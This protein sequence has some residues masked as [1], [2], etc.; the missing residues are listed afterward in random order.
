MKKIASLVT[1]GALLFSVTGVASAYFPHFGGNS[2]TQ[3]GTTYSMT[4]ATSVSGQNSQVGKGQQSMLTG[5]SDSTAYSFTGGNLNFGTT[6]GKV[7]QAATT[8]STTGATSIS[9]GNTQ[10]SYGGYG[11]YHSSTSSSQSMTTGD[12]TSLAG[13]ATVSNVNVVSF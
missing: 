12:S 7:T 1:A 6:S 9:G 5:S 13:S 2:V 11:H 3:S 8:G 10:T 4:G